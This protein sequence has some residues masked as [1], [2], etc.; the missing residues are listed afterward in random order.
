MMFS[1]W[2]SLQNE[3]RSDSGNTSVLHSFPETVGKDVANA[4]VRNLAQTLSIGAT[5]SEPSSLVTDKQVQWTMEVSVC[6]S[7][8][9][10]VQIKNG[11]QKYMHMWYITFIFWFIHLPIN[12]SIHLFIR[13]ACEFLL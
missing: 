13:Y 6:C 1:E 8:L 5:N 9:V 3:I 4:V 11:P 10:I 2:A 7:H 12:P